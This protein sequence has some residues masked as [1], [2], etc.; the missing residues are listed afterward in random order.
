M[1]ENL[2]KHQIFGRNPNYI[3]RIAIIF[4]AESDRNLRI[5]LGCVKLQNYYY[6]KHN[7]RTYFIM[8]RMCKIYYGSCEVIT[9]LQNDT[10]TILV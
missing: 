3:L 6:V 9:V 10:S 2:M 4:S 7:Y 8:S 5:L 1:Q